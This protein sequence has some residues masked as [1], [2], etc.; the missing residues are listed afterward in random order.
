MQTESFVRKV[1]L[2][3]RA[4]NNPHCTVHKKNKI[5]KT[6]LTVLTKQAS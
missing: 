4:F 5:K 6:I 2:P 3:F 1:F